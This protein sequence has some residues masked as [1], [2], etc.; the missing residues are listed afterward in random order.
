MMSEP[1]NAPLALTMEGVSKRF[2][3]TQALDGVS[4]QI[5]AGEIHALLGE[6]GAGKSTLVKILSG[7]TRPDS[8]TISVFGKPADIA[9]ARTAQALGLRTAFQEI[10]LVPDLTVADNLLL[11]EAPVHLGFFLDRRRAAEWVEGVLT[12]LE[13]LDV[14]P[15]MDVRDCALPIRQKLEIA[16]AISREPRILL[17]DEPTSALSSRDVEWL[18]RRIAELRERGTTVVL[19]THRVPE[20]R[21]FCDRLTILRNGRHDGSFAVP[22]ITDQEVVRL[23]IGRSLAA[24]FPTR[25]GLPPARDGTPALAVHGMRIKGQVDD[26]SLDLWPG[27]ILGIAGLQGMGQNELFYALFGMTPTDGG[28]IEVRGDAVALSS[29]RDAIDAL[30]GISLVPEDRKTEA[31]ALKLSGLANVSLPVIDRFARFGW[32]DLARERRAVDRILERVQVHPRALYRA[33]S[34]FSGGNQQKIAIAKW[35]LAESRILLL[36]D[37]TRGVDVGTK[38]EIYLLM[39]EFADAGG[40]VLFYSTDVLE[41]VNL[42]DRVAVMYSGRIRAELSGAEIA[43]ET[44]MRT[45]LGGAAAA[46]APEV[47]MVA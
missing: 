18:A 42:C 26:V 20:V 8:G 40:A 21:R 2:G 10:T 17:L 25:Q 32:L 11:P 19:I 38:H 5:A 1:Q 31:L 33:C 46:A 4:F 30:I 24:T 7:L 28:T 16:R 45:A 39:R 43:E 44:I 3:A 34:S 36:F 6:N 27:E 22:E 37:P 13:L 12:R 23:V 15:R 9:G 41:I 29:P 35:L 14:D 47:G